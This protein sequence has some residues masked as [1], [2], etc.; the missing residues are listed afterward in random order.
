VV[1]VDASYLFRD[2]C[3]AYFFVLF[4]ILTYFV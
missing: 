2:V 4:V 1:V 3:Y